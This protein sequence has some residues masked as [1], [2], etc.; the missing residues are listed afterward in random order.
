[1]TW[2]N[3]A[4]W[5]E[6]ALSTCH[7]PLATPT[8]MPFTCGTRTTSSSPWPHRMRALWPALW[9]P[10][11][12][13]FRRSFPPTSMS[14]ARPTIIR[15]PRRVTLEAAQR[16]QPRHFSRGSYA[17][18]KTLLPLVSFFGFSKLAFCLISGKS[19]TVSWKFFRKI[20]LHQQTDK[21]PKNELFSE[22]LHKML[23]FPVGL[24]Q[25]YLRVFA[26]SF[27]FI[28][29]LYLHWQTW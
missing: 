15:S 14:T 25:D 5:T 19:S 7:L 9:W 21:W 11:S 20:T 6:S 22:S 12:H 2:Q 28:W 10:S 26:V 24:C 17:F 4:R 13:T 1:M 8:L 16:L 23:F 18:N 27:A 29:N 3:T